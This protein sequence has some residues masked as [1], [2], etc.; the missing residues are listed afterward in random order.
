M[1]SIQ[2]IEGKTLAELRAMNVQLD[3][4]QATE[5]EALRTEYLNLQAKF[6]DRKELDNLDWDAEHDKIRDEHFATIDDL[7]MQYKTAGVEIGKLMD[8]RANTTEEAK[9]NE[10]RDKIEEFME[11]RRQLKIRKRECNAQYRADVLAFKK[12]CMATKHERFVELSTA[13]RELRKRRIETK[14]R[15]AELRDAVRVEIGKRLAE[16][17]AEAE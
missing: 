7:D 15:I 17:R 13:E 9:L 12:R 11:Q 8:I 6:H 5:N 14:Q 4:E 10:I 16:E 3:T 1:F 2:D